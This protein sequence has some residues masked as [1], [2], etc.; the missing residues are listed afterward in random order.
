MRL[1]KRRHQTLARINLTPMIDVVFLLLIFFI[2]VTQVSESNKERLILPE[3]EGSVDQKPRVVT[4]N[5]NQEGGYVIS[6]NHLE[7]G[8]VI[9]LFSRELALVGDDPN[10][11]NVVLRV[12]RR[13]DCSSVNHVLNALQRMEILRVRF[14]VQK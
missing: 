5:I 11:I 2:T 3:L 9:A 1:N 7:L 4:V 14:A 10:R 8:A 13:G 12:D 6:G